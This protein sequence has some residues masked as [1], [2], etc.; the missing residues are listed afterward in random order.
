MLKIPRS[1]RGQILIFLAVILPV[2]LGFSALAIDAGY[3]FDHRQR[4]S[5]AADA[6]AIA[7]AFEVKRK[8]DIDPT[9][10]KGYAGDDAKR[11]GFWDGHDGVTVTVHRGPQSG[12]FKGN[13]KY[14]EVIISQDVP[15]F[16]MRMLGTMTMTASARAVAGPEDAS[17][18]V[19]ALNTLDTKY[20]TELDVQSKGGKGTTCSSS[21]GASATTCIDV[22]NCGVV[23]NGDFATASGTE[24]TA[25]EIDVAAAAGSVSGY[26]SPS[27]T[28]NVPPAADPFGDMDQAA[29]FGTSWTCGWTGTKTSKGATTNIGG[30]GQAKLS[31]GTDQYTLNPGVYC[32]NGSTAA[33]DFGGGTIN[34]TVNPADPSPLCDPAKDGIVTFN[35]GIYILNGGGAKWIHVCTAGTGVTFYFTGSTSHSYPSCGS[36]VFASDAPARYEL[37][38]PTS[39]QYEGLLFIRDRTQAACAGNPVKLNFQPSNMI[40]NGAIYF[41]YDHID[42][43][44]STTTDGQYTVLVG[45]TIAFINAA[46]LNSDFKGAGLSGN[47]ATRPGLGE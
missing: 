38:A 21:G 14:V 6:A 7:G 27:P 47:P 16:F 26:V 19:Y 22:P 44:A 42:Y 28:Y 39:G 32:G 29:M 33:M 20:T 13:M 11:N 8:T 4:M 10:L 30:S 25:S 5:A 23:S 24:I 36:T 43:G 37:T 12:P 35:P 46:R 41:P 40:V 34:S 3:L 45:G 17:G 1:E 9:T 18:C 2:L 31:L 15:T